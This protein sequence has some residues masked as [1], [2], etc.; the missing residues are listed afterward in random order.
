QSESDSIIWKDK[1]FKN[2]KFK[3]PTRF[4]LQ[5]GLSNVNKQVFTTNDNWG[6]S[7]DVEYLPA[8]FENS[9]IKQLISN[10]AN[11]SNEVTANLKQNFYDI[12]LLNY[13][14]SSLGNS[15][16]FLVIQN[17]EQISANRNSLITLYN[18]FIISPPYYCSITLTY[19]LASEAAEE[20]FED[21]RGSF[22]FP[23]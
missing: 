14:F 21:I 20:I 18:Y 16:A 11:F 22:Y 3:L 17:S 13:E 5:G 4:K 15:E 6:V 2:F 23:K 9:S 12:K 7:I 1:E 19:P 8:G 10:P